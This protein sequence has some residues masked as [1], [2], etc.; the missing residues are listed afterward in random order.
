MRA[1]I[2]GAAGFVGR[3]L[4]GALAAEG[5]HVT[6]LAQGDALP[7]GDPTAGGAPAGDRPAEAVTWLAGDL[8]DDAHVRAAV[9]AARPDLVVHLA[10]IS[11]V[12]TAASDPATTWDVNV[13]AT[14]RLFHHLEQARGAGQCDPTVLA[15]GSAEQYGRHDPDAMPLRESAE[16][17]PR[18][19]YAATKAAQELLA[20][21]RWRETGLR[22][23]AVRSF[24]HSGPGQDPR[25]LLPALVRRVLALRDA[26]AGPAAMLAMGNLT[27]VR[28][29]LHVGDVVAAY[30]SLWRHGVPGETYNVA[31]GEGRSVRA[32]VDHV[33]ARVGVTATI[34]TDPALV[35]PVDVPCLVGDAT[36]L[37]TTTGW[38]PLRS[39]DDIIDDLLHAATL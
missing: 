14:A 26:G 10:A 16:Q 3:W 37:R 36:R 11:H 28:D 35:R 32:I 13:T 15:V 33:L 29:F 5:V 18:S 7:S 24:N 2:T 4:V 25:F 30:I 12:P 22:V 6:A 9:A 20:L 38:R 39:F 21:E 27:P 31:S 34:T 19:V 23:I 1:L 8:R 17:R